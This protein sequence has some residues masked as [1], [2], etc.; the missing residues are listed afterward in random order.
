MRQKAHFKAHLVDKEQGIGQVKSKYAK[1]EHFKQ[2]TAL[3]PSRIHREFSI[4]N[5]KKSALSHQSKNWKWRIL[6]CDDFRALWWSDYGAKTLIKCYSQAQSVPL[7]TT[8]ITKPS[9]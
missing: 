2:K 8:S 1:S 7:K 5:Y 9:W 3:F 4:E 6:D